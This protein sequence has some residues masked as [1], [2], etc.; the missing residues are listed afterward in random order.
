MAAPESQA[1]QK[2]IEID[3]IDNDVVILKGGGLRKVILVSGVNMELKSE[4]EQNLIYYAYQDLLNGLDFS[5]QFVAHSRKLN[6]DPYLALLESYRSKETNELLRSQIVEYKE[7]IKSFV[8]QNEIMTKTFFIVVPYDPITVA[9][10]EGLSKF[11]PFLKNTTPSAQTQK[12]EMREKN[13][14][15]LNQ[16]VDQV[17]SGLQ[18]IGLR[19]VILNREELIELFYNLYNPESVEKKDLAIAKE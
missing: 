11:L 17:I 4:E 2:F 8:Q 5:V 13:L 18:P 9:G 19:A 16:R 6:I 12:G 15:Q 3:S 10:S 1:T 14:T 7:F